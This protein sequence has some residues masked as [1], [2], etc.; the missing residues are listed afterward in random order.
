VRGCGVGVGV[1]IGA[2]GGDARVL[3][4]ILARACAATPP[5]T[6]ELASLVHLVNDTDLS[7]F[8]Q[9]AEALASSPRNHAFATR[10]L[11]APTRDWQIVATQFGG[12]DA[13]LWLALSGLLAGRGREASDA[14]QLP[15]D[16]LLEICIV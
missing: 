8:T 6:V 15:A 16:A 12:H 10:V 2:S 13:Q 14:L 1:G 4:Q 9:F 3:A 5:F 7:D 11:F